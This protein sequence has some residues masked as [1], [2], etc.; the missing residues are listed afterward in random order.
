V[1][2]CLIPMEAV[3]PQLARI[4]CSNA[5]DGFADAEL[6]IEAVDEIQATKRR[7][8]TEAEDQIGPTAV[9]ATATTAFTVR[10]LQEGLARP[11]RLIGLHFSC[12]AAALRQVEVAAGPATDPAAVARVRHWLAANGREGVLVA[13]R[14]GRV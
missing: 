1:Q 6:V 7:V 13:D 2:R 10:S 4:V 11:E 3:P 9:L 5:F 12:P 8:L 14:P